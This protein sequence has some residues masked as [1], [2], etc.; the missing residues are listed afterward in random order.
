MADYK[1]L[2]VSEAL[3]RISG[4]LAPKVTQTHISNSV[5]ANNYVPLDPSLAAQAVVN[6]PMPQNLSKTGFDY[7][8]DAAVALGKGI[9]SVPQAASSAASVAVPTVSDLKP[10]F[11]T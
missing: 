10:W 3:Q 2:Q 7:A 9:V 5:Y 8:Q 11:A 1:S 4:S 6:R